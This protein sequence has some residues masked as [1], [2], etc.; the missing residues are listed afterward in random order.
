MSTKGYHEL[1]EAIQEQLSKMDE[2]DLKIVLK[3]LE[4]L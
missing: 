1:W 2:T 3:F 4:T